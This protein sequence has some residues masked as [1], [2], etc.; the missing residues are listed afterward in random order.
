MKEV[1]YKTCPNC[2]KEVTK[3]Y[4]IDKHKLWEL[5]VCEQCY[6]N[7]VNYKP[8]ISAENYLLKE[9]QL[10]EK[11]NLAQ[12]EIDQ[13]KEDSLKWRNN[14]LTL[15]KQLQLTQVDNNMLT[16]NNC[17]LQEELSAL[18]EKVREFLCWKDTLFYE[19][20]LNK[21]LEEL[22]EMVNR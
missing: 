15:A 3:L 8:V 10:L 12:Q 9:E 22:K 14:N 21:C 17:S 20:K 13:L 4:Y 2:K 16:S 1:K 18:K 19:D 11:L 5:L 6:N 7:Y